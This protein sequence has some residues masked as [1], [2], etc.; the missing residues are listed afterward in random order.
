M[1][2][3]FIFINVN[4]DVGMESSESIPISLGYVLASVKAA[5]SDGIIIDDLLD[6]PLTLNS[7]EVWIRRFE[8]TVVGF[9][10][11]QSTMN[12]IRYLCRYIKSRHRHLKVALGGPQIAAMPM[13][14][15]KDLE[16]VDALIHGDGEIVMPEL[17]RALDRG[18]SL[19]TVAGIS[20][21]EDGRLVNTG[22]PPSPPD[23][24][25]EYPSPYLSNIIN[26]EGKDTAILLSS[27]GCRHVCRFCITPSIC[28]GKVRTHSVE[29]TLAE[30]ELLASNGIERFWFADPNFTE[31][32]E[33]TERLLQEKIARGITNPFWLQ[34]R[35]DLVDPP[36]L[37][38]LREAGADTI[39]FG[40]ESGSAGVLEGTNKKIVLDQ[41]RENV[42]AAQKLEMET[43][44]FT[45]FGLPGE[46]VEDA[47]ATLEFVRSLGIPIQSNS[48]SQQAQLYFGAIY[49]RNPERWGYKPFAS[50]IPG[51]MSVGD[52]YETDWM[53][54]ADIRKV[55]NMWVLA[56]EKM[57]RDVYY[58]QNVFEIL[59]FLLNNGADLLDEPNYY[60][61]GALAAAAIEEKELLLLFLHGLRRFPGV[62]SETL[63]DL[64]EALSLFEQ[65]D[66]PIG[67]TDRVIFDSRSFLDGVPFTGIS[68]KYWDV[69]LGRGLLLDS[70]EQG[71]IGIRPG[72]ETSFEFTFPEDYVQVELRG[73]T[74]E[75]NAV[76]HKAFKTLHVETIEDI[77]AANCRNTYDLADLD[78]LSEHNEILYFLALRDSPAETLLKKPRHFLML[79]HKLAKLGKKD[80]VFALVKLVEDNS[81][82]LKALAESLAAAG[83]CQ[84]AIE[85]YEQ[86]GEALADSVIKKAQCLI[87]VDQPKEALNILES[88]ENHSGLEYHETLLEA[89]KRGRPVSNRIPSL[90]HHVLDL[91][92]QAALDRERFH[93]RSASVTPL[94]HGMSDNTGS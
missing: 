94:V 54:E 69:L 75:V 23:N 57:E 13:E 77:E 87:R 63:G 40:L 21:R 89:L 56:N 62:D 88:L 55:R 42:L 86:A 39:A 10:A 67:P 78:L 5:G 91:K 30:M 44:L 82:A 3:R 53:S 11:Y 68:G 28:K 64:I 92:I 7:L 50:Q 22:Q 1:N 32:R 60:V 37:E 51:Y 52:A 38:M 19:Q 71:F 46:A 83:K 36:L 16:D 70:F 25:D 76:V 90:E 4:H 81:K 59:D 18:E 80:H 43:E 35:T 9:T 14:A 45:I 41:V 79:T 61:F 66:G 15:L 49:A 2:S 33:R 65:F 84:W 34:T 73:K 29:R 74:V 93:S 27:R 85:I 8:P 12:R 47:K 6:R 72:E 26:L 20:Y 17:A 31:N 48:G 24:L 58:K